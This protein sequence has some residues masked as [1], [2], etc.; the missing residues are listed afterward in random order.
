MKLFTL[1]IDHLFAYIIVST[2]LFIGSV[3]LQ[4]QIGKTVK[5]WAYNPP[6]KIDPPKVVDSSWN[7]NPIDAFIFSNLQ[8]QNLSPNPPADRLVLLKRACYDLTG[9]PPSQEQVNA[10]LQDDSPNAWKKLI[11]QLLD[12]PH[13]GEKWGRHW[14]DVVR[15]AESN[16]YERDG[17]KRNMWKYRDYVINA[18]N[19]DMPYDE[20]IIDQI[21]GDVKPNATVDSTIATGFLHLGLYDDEPADEEQ[22]H[23][24]YYDDIIN[25]VSRSMLATSMS[26][27]RC[28]DHKIDPISQKEYYQFLAYFRN[29]KIPFLIRNQDIATISVFD[30]A[31]EAHLTEQLEEAVRNITVPRLKMW[32]AANHLYGYVP[33]QPTID[34]NYPTDLRF[35]FVMEDWNTA[36]SDLDNIDYLYEGVLPDGKINLA[37]DITQITPAK[38]VPSSY[39]VSGKFNQAEAGSQTFRVTVNGGAWMYLGEEL[40]FSKVGTNTITEDFSIDLPGG[41]HDLKLIFGRHSAMNLE[42]SMLTDGQPASWVST[43]KWNRIKAIG[44]G[45]AKKSP[46]TEEKWIAVFKENMELEKTVLEAFKPLEE[47]ME[48][49]LATAASNTAGQKSTHILF[50]GNPHAPGEEVQPGIP[51]VLNTTVTSNSVRDADRRLQLAEWIASDSNS[52]TARVAVNRIWQHHFGRGL[53][54]SSDD[55]G[56]LGSEPTHPEL[57]DWLANEFASQGWTMKNLHRLIMTSNTYKMSSTPNDKALEKDPLNDHFWRYNM[58]RLT[59]EEIRDTVLTVADNFN[60]QV[61]GPSVFPTLQT[62]VLATASK[63]ESRWDLKAGAE[64]QNRRSIYTFTRRSLQDPMMSSFD[65]A[66]TDTACAV[67]FNTTVPGQALTMMNSSFMADHSERLAQQLIKQSS[68][69]VESLVNTGFDTVLGRLPDDAELKISIDLIHSMQQDYGHDFNTAVNRFALMMLNLNEFLF[70]D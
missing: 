5:H 35:G 41:S 39:V 26:C 10:F 40:V 70:L 64:H 24:D 21:A 61:G 2:C 29:L 38:D 34:E 63:A 55:F 66:D 53:V 68:Y 19:Q 33:D 43:A 65:V 15:W 60:P 28:H 22:F 48:G 9:L 37:T 57:L 46:D 45:V 42:I 49:S 52:V 47:K 69:G 59:A 18:V 14:L 50:R 32:E 8:K 51:S 4:A 56:G 13:Y 12:S 36:H 67:R 16:G 7:S 62:E 25:T 6:A 30:P 3:R 11:D 20:F 23:F 17:D 58:R 27:A 1:R 54:R 44:N 31:T